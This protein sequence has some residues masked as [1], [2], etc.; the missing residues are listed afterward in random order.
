MAEGERLTAERVEGE[1]VVHRVE[2]RADSCSVGELGGVDVDMRHSA[3]GRPA[4]PA[5]QPGVHLGP[6]SANGHDDRQ[7]VLAAPGPA[8]QPADEGQQFGHAPGGEPVT[9]PVRTGLHGHLGTPI[10]RSSGRSIQC[11]SG[12][13]PAGLRTGR[14]GQNARRFDGNP[15]GPSA[16]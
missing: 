6:G 2:Q 16:R 8:Q 10:L 14:L 5:Q 7:I 12:L 9:C 3:V 11:R 1:L 4:E 13:P 15:S